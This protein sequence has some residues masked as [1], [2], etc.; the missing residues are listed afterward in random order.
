MSRL[1]L[2]EAQG[3]AVI[4]VGTKVVAVC[5]CGLSKNKPFCDGSHQ[6]VRD[7]AAHRVY[8]YD[9]EHHRVPL[10]SLFPPIPKKLTVE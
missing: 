2:H 3:P 7:E 1:V 8:V 9:A 4:Q 6:K 10:D 5:Q